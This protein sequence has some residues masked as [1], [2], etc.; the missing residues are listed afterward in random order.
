M[1][2]DPKLSIVLPA[3]KERD[4]LEV[5][6]PQIEDVFRDVSIE[7][8]IVDD[9]SG[10]GTKELAQALQAT[11]GNV[12]L[13]ERPGLLGIGSAL[14]DGYNKARGEY[15]LSSD[16]DLSFRAE[17]MRSLFETIQKEWDLALGYKVYVSEEVLRQTFREWCKTYVFSQISNGIIGVLAGVGLKNYN[18][19]FRAIRAS[20]W[21]KLRT[22]EDRHFF[23]LEMIL[24]AKRRG[25][26]ITEIPV[27]FHVRRFGESK[28]SFF[29][30]APK[31]FLKLLWYTFFE[32]SS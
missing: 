5:L 14:R 29:R 16:A 10:D 28:V 7:V 25:A 23:L 11:Y 4:N 26:R 1:T 2:Q 12:V 19:N 18:T 21:K 24:R 6:I 30:Q 13:L 32:R 3:Y 31:Y 8:V 17:D 15:I 20:F 9:N 22:V 27:S